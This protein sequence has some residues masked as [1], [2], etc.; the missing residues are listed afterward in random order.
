MPST[1]EPEQRPSCQILNF[2]YD[3]D[4]SS[5]LTALIN[6]VRF[7]I[8]VDADV[9]RKS[10]PKHQLK[11]YLSLL[12]IVR[13]A[14]SESASMRTSPTP[15]P[16]EK[17]PSENPKHL[18][19]SDRRSS[20]S[21]GDRDSAIDV[22]ADRKTQSKDSTPGAEVNPDTAEVDLANWILS[23]FEAETKEFAPTVSR[24]EE[25]SLHEWYAGITYF[26]DLDIQEG[27]IAPRRL[28]NTS[29]LQTRI[30]NLVPRMRMP[31][32][33]QEMDL[34]WKSASDILVVS[35]VPEPASVHPGLVRVGDELQ[36]FKP[37]DPSQPQTTKREI[38]VL[39]RVARLD[40][41]GKIRIP[42]LLGLVAYEN[43]STEIMGLL[44]TAI[45]NPRPLTTLL[46]SEVPE[47]QRLRWADESKDMVK[48][49]HEHG[50]IWGDAK[51]DN[52]IVDENEDLWM[53]DFGGSY[54]EG[55]ID[56]EIAETKDGDKMG[57]EKVVNALV[58]PDENTF[59]PEDEDADDSDYAP[60]RKRRRDPTEDP[61]KSN[62]KKSRR[63]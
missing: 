31:K 56:P 11:N 50:L 28:E 43:S 61:E 2:F 55:W 42:T 25:R 29:E 49:I 1:D 39:E 22:S 10:A 45:S 47:A 6:G 9:L 7:H 63:G 34:P 15:A 48:F 41:Q 27:G 35:E 38:K 21:E 23:F 14:A 44:M 17:V 52:F 57:V 59:D 51:A 24:D 36:F 5:A 33:V 60:A 19:R 30:K 46:S 16:S 20:N 62:H 3:D 58:D 12:R 18:R 40:L 8:V 26:F 32:Y 4:D 37:V 13:S 54:T 53:I